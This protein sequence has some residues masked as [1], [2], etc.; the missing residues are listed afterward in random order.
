MEHLT[1][2]FVKTRKPHECWGC[3]LLFPAGTTMK[4]IVTVDQGEFGSSYWCDDCREY[5]Q[6][7]DY[8]ET[9]DG[10][11]FG[12]IGDRMEEEQAIRESI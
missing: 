7:L 4:Y 1:S 3:G 6:S 5:V 11:A 12:E 10:F 2:K 9:Q 8:Y